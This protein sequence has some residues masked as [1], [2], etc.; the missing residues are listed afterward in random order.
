MGH[1][2]EIQQLSAI[3]TVIWCVYSNN[4]LI[5]TLTTAKLNASGLR[6]V[7][8]LEDYKFKIDYCSGIESEKARITTGQWQSYWFRQ[9]LFTM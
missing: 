6:W 7:A 8:E 4:Q 5:Y 3:R 9:Q 1:H 2:C